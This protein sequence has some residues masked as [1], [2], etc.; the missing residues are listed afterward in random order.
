MCEQALGEEIAGG[1]AALVFEGVDQVFQ[2]RLEDAQSQDR[3]VVGDALV[4]AERAGRPCLGEGHGA[5]RAGGGGLEDGEFQEA[6]GA[7]G[8]ARVG[9]R[10]TGGADAGVAEVE[11][12]AGELAEGHARIL[13]RFR[14]RHD[15]SQVRVESAM[16]L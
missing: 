11:D 10:F 4:F 2:W 7:E 16:P 15:W 9:G 8:L 5:L 1:P 14:Y 6:D 12:V 13:P 3:F